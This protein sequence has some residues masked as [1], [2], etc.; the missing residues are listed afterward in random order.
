MHQF[1]SSCE[2]HP[3]AGPS[4]VCSMFRWWD[5]IFWNMNLFSSLCFW[6]RSLKDVLDGRDFLFGSG[7]FTYATVFCNA[8]L[9]SMLLWKRLE[10]T[11]GCVWSLKIETAS[12]VRRISNPRCGFEFD[13]HERFHS[14]T[15]RILVCLFLSLF[16]CFSGPTKTKVCSREASQQLALGQRA[17]PAAPTGSHVTFWW[18]PGT[19]TNI[20]TFLLKWSFLTLTLTLTNV[21]ATHNRVDLE[22]LTSL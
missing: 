2:Y 12:S 18:D 17:A 3:H 9:C 10:A 14:Q 21:V 1:S 13:S 6:E 19:I 22:G 11:T 20:C 7:P 4:L 8:S 5:F 15:V 16:V